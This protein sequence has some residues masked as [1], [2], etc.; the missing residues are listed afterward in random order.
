MGWD[1]AQADGIVRLS[2]AVT[3]WKKVTSF[4]QEI[5]PEKE[6]AIASTDRA[7]LFTNFEKTYNF[8][9]PPSRMPHDTVLGKLLRSHFGSR[10]KCW[11]LSMTA[12]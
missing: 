6:V 10:L 1:P 12:A 3:A 8:L 5:D 7:R 11:L 2:Y 4:G 9:L